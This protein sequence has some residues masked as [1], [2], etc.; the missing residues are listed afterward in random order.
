MKNIINFMKHHLIGFS[1]FTYTVAA[2]LLTIAMML[3]IFIGLP[4]GIMISLIELFSIIR[5]WVIP[6]G[7][8]LVLLYIYSVTEMITA[9]LGELNAVREAQR[10]IEVAEYMEQREIEREQLREEITEELL[11]KRG[12]T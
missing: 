5:F 11:A 3:F 8:I 1:K 7:F 12:A 2:G 4:A 6:I 10:K 9:E